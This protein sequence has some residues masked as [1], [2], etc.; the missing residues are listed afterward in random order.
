MNK[1]LLIASALLVIFTLSGVKATGDEYAPDSDHYNFQGVC[2]VKNCLNYND[3]SLMETFSNLNLSKLAKE[4]QSD[5]KKNPNLRKKF[6][7]KESVLDPTKTTLFAKG[8]IEKGSTLALFHMSQ[9]I[10]SA[11]LDISMFN[12]TSYYQEH[13]KIL[14]K[15]EFSKTGEDELLILT[16]NI[17]Y[18]LYHIEDSPYKH[19]LRLYFNMDRKPSPLLSLSEYEIHLL[20]VAKEAFEYIRGV[21]RYIEGIWDNLGFRLIK[22][23]TES[24]RRKIFAD[25]S[26]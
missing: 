13:Q 11:K 5:I 26:K 3:T 14:N 1:K 6:T 8:S 2:H 15:I 7:I 20:K 17:L 10:S 21:R 25:R 12:H 9:V 23:L 4:L 24:D 18:H 16:L 19:D 22:E